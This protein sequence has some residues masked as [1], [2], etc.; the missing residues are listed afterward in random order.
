VLSE[1]VKKNKQKTLKIIGS[2]NTTDA[3]L[4]PPSLTTLSSPVHSAIVSQQY[5]SF[6]IIFTP[7]QSS[8]LFKLNYI[9]LSRFLVIVEN[10]LCR[11]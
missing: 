2:G 9:G 1:I 8:K 4:H 5:E 7:Q 6:S 11:F 3:A 10:N